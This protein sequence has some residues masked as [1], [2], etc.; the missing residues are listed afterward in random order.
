VSTFPAV[1]LDLRPELFLGGAWT[2]VSADVYQRDGTSAPV[3][4][5]RGRQ[6]ESSQVNPSSAA[7]QM[8]N[9]SGNYSPLNPLGAYYGQLGQNTP[10]RFSVPAQLNYLRLEGDG[11][12]TTDDFSDYAS[13]PDAAPL[14]ISGDI[15]V[16]AD[17]WLTGLSGNGAVLAAKT[18]GTLLAWALFLNDGGYPEFAWTPDGT[19]VSSVTCGAAIPLRARIAVRATLDHTTGTVTFYTAPTMAG[20]FTALGTAASGTGGTSVG[21]YTGGSLGVYAGGWSQPSPFAQGSLRGRMYEVQI[22][23]GIAGT[24]E[25]DPVFSAQTA[26]VTFFTDSKSN[27]W[28]LNA[29]AEISDRDYRYH[30]QL[31]SQPPKWD[32]TGAD[33]YIAEQAGG[34]LR[35]L[36][37]GSPPQQSAMY[38]FYASMET[39]AIAG[40]WP[41]EDGTGATQLASGIAGPPMYFSGTPSLAS[42]TSFPGSQAVPVSNNAAF[43]AKPD[44]GS[45][46]WTD[47][48][49]RFLLQIPAAG[50]TPPVTGGI[51]AN[52]STTGTIALL[53]LLYTTTAGGTLSLNCYDATG[54]NLG[55]FGDIT[56]ANGQ[57][58]AV[59]VSVAP[60]LGSVTAALAAVTPGG[61]SSAPAGST[62][63]G[64]SVG[65]VTGVQFDPDGSLSGTAFGH[66]AILPAYASILALSDYTCP[67]GSTTGPLN[68][69]AGEPAGI[70]Y[71]RICGE[72]NTGFRGIGW[73]YGSVQMGDQPADTVATLLQECEDA[74]R[75]QEFEPRACLGLGYRTRSSLYN[76]AAAL[77]LDYSQ[78]QPGGVQGGGTSSELE[79]AFDDQYR[80]NDWTVSRSSARSQGVS[81][82]YVLNDGSAMSAGIIGDYADSG[83]LNLFT[84]TLASDVA[85]WLVHLGTV[86]ELRWPAI[87]LNLA[88]PAMSSLYYAV[89]NADIGDCLSLSNLPGQVTGGP[90]KQLLW[91]VKES[92]GGFWHTVEI[93]GVPESP[94]EVAAAGVTH[95]DTDGTTL[96]AGVSSGATSMGF[97][98]GTGTLWSTSGGDYPLDVMIAGEQVTVTAMSGSSSPQ[99][100]TV[101][102]SVNGVVKAQ[103]INASVDIYPPPVLAL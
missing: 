20:S 7:W 66:L 26:G 34:L 63:G 35:L 6:D 52:I 101:T 67:D 82:R 9:R 92:L 13:A 48:D 45:V 16:R 86:N 76:Q 33:Q 99:T 18:D 21:I 91:Q 31:S 58:F 24:L 37:Q 11:F 77:T 80:R 25:A 96:H 5:T 38:R 46:S 4:I 103:A 10:V 97:E 65:A 30:G 55:S 41:M 100:A 44:W 88:R 54:S 47:N 36:G 56:G 59:Q 22:L 95:A 94:Y 62:V 2:D 19:T 39:S 1:P 14:H 79:P 61:A 8:N 40:W 90:A 15:D 69:W 3:V 87:P 53:Q 17:F 60:V 74:D 70:R 75:G 102:R 68:A 29:S 51:V 64:G 98:T 85:A 23:S 57:V 43:T 73:L 42:S 81:F 78:S 28:S 32:A 84:D 89:L 83:S 72:E 50:E 49:V 27:V 71:G 12:N 93:T